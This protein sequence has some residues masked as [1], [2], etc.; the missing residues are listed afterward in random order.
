[1]KKIMYVALLI[2]MTFSISMPVMAKISKYEKT[3][4][5]SGCSNKRVNK[6]VYCS[7]HTCRTACCWGKATSSDGKYCRTHTPK[8]VTKTTTTTKKYTST[9]KKTTSSSKSKKKSSW[10]CY[11]EGY[12]DVYFNEDYDWDRYWSD[13]DYADGV[14]D[15]MDELDW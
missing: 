12:E 10:E 14:D 2:V 7:T 11:D 15:A 5:I 4:C 6:G 8:N 9:S 1:M 3:C 13:S